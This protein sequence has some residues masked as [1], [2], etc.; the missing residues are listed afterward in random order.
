MLAIVSKRDFCCFLKRPHKT[1][2]LLFFMIITSPSDYPDGYFLSS[3][4]AYLNIRNSM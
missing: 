2:E 1:G 4:R 3:G